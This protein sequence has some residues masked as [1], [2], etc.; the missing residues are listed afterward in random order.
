MSNLDLAVIGNCNVAALL[1]S[2]A[3]I[4]WGCFP[5]FDGDPAFCAL[6]AGTGE[7]RAGFYDIELAGFQRAE[8]RYLPNTAIV[9][10]ILHDGSGA[11]VRVLDFAPRLEQYGRA[12]R[13]MMLVRTITPLHGSPRLRVRLRPLGGYGSAEPTHTRGSNHI[14]YV[15]PDVTLRLTTDASI[16]AVLEERFFVL[17]EALTLVLGPDETLP[18]APGHVGRQFYDQTLHYWEGWTRG[19]SI[20]FDWQEAVIRAAITLKLCTFEDTGAVVAAL[21]TSIPEAADSGR[22]WD[23]RFCWVRDAYFV[24]HALNHLGATKTME[25][26]LHYIVNIASGAAE[27]RLQPVY[28]ISGRARLTEETVQTLPGYRGMGPVRVGNDAYS[29]TQHDVYGSIVLAATQY[30]FDQRLTR[31]GDAAS[32]HRLERLGERAAK[33]Y[34]QP[35]AGLWE[36]RGRQRVHTFSSVMC[37]AACDRLARIAAYLGEKE[38]EEYWRSTA[39]HIHAQICRLGWNERL[40]SFTESFGR[41]ELDASMLLLRH[42]GFL[43]ADDP[44][45]VSTVEAIERDLVRGRHVFRYSA[46]DDFGTPETAFNIC[47]FWYID[48]LADIGRREQARELFEHMLSCR[49]SCGLLSEDIDPKTHELWGNFPQTYSMVGIIKVAARLSRSWE[50]AL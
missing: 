13:P 11:A 45:F 26:F 42:L 33:L 31:R 38:R 40:G 12:F 28:A 49:S 3:R 21:T 18:D 30:F 4:V 5:R 9:D 19:L 6:L 48:A 20:P 10:T 32:F 25:Q 47:S 7:P 44:R 2:R 37:W 15:L 24:V 27:G 29:Q 17:D 8:Q 46:A 39:A 35:D 41:E 23:Y 1:D 34:D 36:Y 50:D 22:N 16:T 14:R 43:R